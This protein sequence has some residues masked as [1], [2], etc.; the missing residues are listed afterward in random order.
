MRLEPPPHLFSLAKERANTVMRSVKGS[1]R[2]LVASSYSWHRVPFCVQ[3]HC[4]FPILQITSHSSLNSL[5]WGTF[6]PFSPHQS[7]PLPPTKLGAYW[8][9][10]HAVFSKYSINMFNNNLFQPLIFPGWILLNPS[11]D[12]Y[13]WFFLTLRGNIFLLIFLC[14]QLSGR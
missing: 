1:L 12:F 8:N 5:F 7:S 3:H 4:T 13:E 2:S 6:L 14:Q 10:E 11:W 9:S